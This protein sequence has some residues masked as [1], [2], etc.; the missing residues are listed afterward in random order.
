MNR[1]PLFVV[2]AFVLGAVTSACT[3]GVAPTTA[4][5]P[6]ALQS[7]T[8]QEPGQPWER[9]AAA[10]R[11][12]GKVMMYGELGPILRDRLT[13][14][15]QRQSGVQIEYVAGKSPEIAQRYLT[16]RT[17]NLFLADVLVTGQTTT[18]TM[19]KPKGVL[20]A[21]KPLLISP[22]LQDPKVW[23]RGGVPFLDKDEMVVSLI[24]AYRSYI[25]INTQLVKEGEIA[26]YQDL[27]NPRW[28]GKITLIDPTTPG[29][30]A[31]WVAFVLL[32][33]MGREKGEKF[34]RD[35][36]A[37]DLA[38]TRDNRL[39]VETVARGKYA[40]AI[41]PLPQAVADLSQAG[42]PIAWA[43]MKEG[44]MMLSGAFAAAVPDKLGHPNAATLMVNYLLSKQGQL[45]LSEAAGMPP[46]RMDVPSTFALPG[47]APPP[48][49]PVW[50]EDEENILK[51]PTFYPLSKE[52]FRIQQ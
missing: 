25:V 16:E 14:H 5:A 37:Q 39:H 33:T 7:S 20:G 43:Y 15:F 11:S 32:K 29:A 10:A 4:P 9:V 48:G 1:M 38:I 46:G 22:E 28:K 17:A 41:G 21:I 3:G 52:I 42:A 27:L 45:D 30:G 36:A 26:S 50:Q 24:S 49:G 40:V 19:L 6:A 35:L 2:L 44:G 51:Q 23:P 18:L 34:L 31:S 12:E 47:T 8:K 13:E